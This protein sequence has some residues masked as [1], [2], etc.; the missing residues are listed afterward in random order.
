MNLDFI[1]KHEGLRLNAYIDP[2]G[3]PTIGY[4]TIV[5]EDGTKVKIGD[6]IT[7]EQ[8]E[9]LLSK[10][11]ERRWNAVKHAFHVQLN[12]NQKTA[13]ISFA[14][15][16]GVGALMG[17]T[18]LK[19]INQKMPPDSIREAWMLWV[20]GRKDGKLVTLPG[21]VTRRKEECDLF[22]S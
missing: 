6:S 22:F 5:Y 4:G 8:A 16:L 21:L 17:S 12:D 3:V 15:N 10:D 2:V 1:K 18:L 19:R 9:S 11:A 14:Y 13:I 20:K 7:K